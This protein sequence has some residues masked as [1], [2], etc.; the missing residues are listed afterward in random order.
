M[1]ANN[2]TGVIFPIEE[3]ASHLKDQG[4]AF[5]TDAVQAIGKIPINLHEVP[6]DMLSLS[7][8]K[9]HGPK[10]IGALYVR[11]GTKFSPFLMGGAPGAGPPRRRR[12][13]HR[14]TWQGK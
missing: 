4:V 14:G 12:G 9:L 10:G 1:W 6:V 8:H 7:G 2:E 5:H 11:K 13:F 3:I